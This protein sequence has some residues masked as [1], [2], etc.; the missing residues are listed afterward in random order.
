MAAPPIPLGLI[1]ALSDLALNPIF[2]SASFA[3]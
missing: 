2:T 1:D 3:A